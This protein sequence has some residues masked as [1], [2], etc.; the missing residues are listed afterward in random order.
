MPLMHLTKTAVERMP[1]TENGQKLF[2]DTELKGFGLLVSRQFKS[3]VA[4]KD[5]RGRSR[6]IN[7][8]RHGTWTTDQARKEA[9]R[10][11][12]SMDIGKDPV[13]EEKADTASRLTL[14]NSYHLHQ[15]LLKRK[16]SAKGTL[17]SY[18]LTMNSYLRDWWDKPID[19]ISRS[20]VR[21][22]HTF[23]R[24]ARGEI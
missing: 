15:E 10:L 2:F 24:W 16:D 23:N 21:Q 19:K 1:F 9:R 8:G 7:I 3:Y 5:V 4:Q 17:D 6:R 22:K 11:L 13:E 12:T 20:E 14:I 18:E